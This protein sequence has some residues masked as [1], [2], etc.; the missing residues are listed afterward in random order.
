MMAMRPSI[1]TVT[2]YRDTQK[3]GEDPVRGRATGFG[4]GEKK[5]APVKGA[6]LANTA[7]GQWLCY[8][9]LPFPF[10]GVVW[11][12]SGTSSSVTGHCVPVSGW[13]W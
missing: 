7:V 2:G 12:S 10:V 13:I 6:A 9:F 11:K 5:A 1:G 8:L 4:V 3:G